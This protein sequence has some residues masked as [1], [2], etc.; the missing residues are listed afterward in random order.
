MIT[1]FLITLIQKEIV[2]PAI[3]SDKFKKT[4]GASA[5]SRAKM[6]IILVVLTVITVIITALLGLKSYSKPQ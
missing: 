6:E 4:V 5:S 2:D 1:D 3:A